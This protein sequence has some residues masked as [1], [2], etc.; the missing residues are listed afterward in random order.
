MTAPVKMAPARVYFF[1]RRLFAVA[2]WFV[3]RP[4]FTGL[5]HIP[6]DGPFLVVCNHISFFDIPLMF[7]M[8]SRR[9]MVMFC[10]DK[11]RKVPLVG[12]F[13][14]MMGVIWVVRGE[15]D[16]DAIK[17]SLGHLKGG[18]IL[19]VAPE[20]TRSHTGPLQPGKTG[21][22]YLADRTNVPILPIAV[23]GQEATVRNL[24]RLRRTEVTGVIGQPF[25]L[26]PGGRAK[27]E[28]LQECTDLIMC[29]LAALLP[30]PYRGVYAD[31]PRL[32]DLLAEGA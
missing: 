12:P 11:W 28:K 26:P 4:K 25:G 6:K 21:A 30:P 32:R 5:E 8:Q 17:Q 14:E 19:A 3:F 24:K 7:I 15:P 13:C 9:Q 2:A 29:R 1:V 10:A 23:W 27:S 18:G 31:H 16:M 22:A 20:G